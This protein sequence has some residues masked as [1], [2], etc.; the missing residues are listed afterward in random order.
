MDPSELSL[1]HTGVL[2]V[3]HGTR[4]VEGQREF[5]RLGE[6]VAQQLGPIP[7][8]ACFL[9]LA[10]PSIDVAVREL[11]GAGVRQLI[12]APVLLFAANHSER[13]IPELVAKAIAAVNSEGGEISSTTQLP[14]LDSCPELVTLSA[15][16]FR[17][18][19]EIAKEGGKDAVL[20]MVGRGSSHS[21]AVQAMRQFTERRVD[22]TRVAR[23]ETCFL[24]VAEPRL[25]EALAKIAEQ[26]PTAVVVQP[27]LLF[28][29]RLTQRIA[30][31][32]ATLRQTHPET[33][34]IVASHLGPTADLAAVIVQAIGERL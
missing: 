15:N 3:G 10:E 4:D 28:S 9:E 26:R 25:E 16:R 7:S 19:V 24:A 27:H 11:A 20:L 31:Q 5:L 33:E 12:V 17:K 23:A 22:V 29:G 21:E 1:T 8:A 2:L 32:V 13:D 14:V 30:A 18:A 6:L 34:W